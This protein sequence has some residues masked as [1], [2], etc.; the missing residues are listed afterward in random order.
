[1]PRL[2]GWFIRASLVYLVLGFSLG[3]L[4]LINEGLTILPSVSRF[5]PIHMEFLI[6]GWLIQLAMGVAYWILPRN[7]TGLPRGNEALAWSS[8]A[9]LN[10]GIL[11]S[12]LYGVLNFSWLELV[13]RVLETLGILLFLLGAWRRVRASR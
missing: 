12:A 4:M 3:S 9:F 10:V 13:G 1:M 6:I 7:P 5:L 11:I 8:L 2:S